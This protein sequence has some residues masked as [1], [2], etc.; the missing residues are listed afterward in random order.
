MSTARRRSRLNLP[1]TRKG[2]TITGRN[3]G[4]STGRSSNRSGRTRAIFSIVSKAAVSSC[5]ADDDGGYGV[6]GRV[7]RWICIGVGLKAAFRRRSGGWAL[8]D[9]QL[10]ET[11]HQIG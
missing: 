2:T 5:K 4:H 11:C 3:I 1:A 10:L 8:S 7:A 6:L 9:C